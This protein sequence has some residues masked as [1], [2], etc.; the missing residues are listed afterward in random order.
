MRIPLFAAALIAAATFAAIP[1][2]AQ[3]APAPGARPAAPLP[4]GLPISLAEA[5]RVADA[6]VAKAAF[7]S[8][9]AV[10]GPGGE[11]IYLEKMDNS[12]NSTSEL[13]IKKART[14]A[15]FR[16]PSLFFEQALAGGRVVISQLG[17]TAVGGGIPIVMHGRIVGAI[18]ASGAPGSDGDVAAAQAGLDALK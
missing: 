10:V 13:A 11:V 9:I 12:N 5:K 4:Y 2:H 17:L 1:S 18:G 7:P 14:A 3:Q 15:A 6:A 16:R 8:A